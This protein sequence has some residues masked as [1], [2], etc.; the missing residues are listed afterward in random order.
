M[1]HVTEKNFGWIDWMSGEIYERTR[2]SVE[3]AR[4]LLRLMRFL[5]NQKLLFAQKSCRLEQ[6]SGGFNRNCDPFVFHQTFG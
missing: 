5:A 2:I 3:V 4:V 6:N 1:C